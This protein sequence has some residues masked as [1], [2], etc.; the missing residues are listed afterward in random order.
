[1][2]MLPPIHGYR[3][4]TLDKGDPHVSNTDP[5]HNYAKFPTAPPIYLGE[6]I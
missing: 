6:N 2:G 5:R 3:G 1:V 4:G